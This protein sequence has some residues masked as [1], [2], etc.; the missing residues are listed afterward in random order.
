MQDSIFS[1]F[2]IRTQINKLLSLLVGTLVFSFSAD[3]FAQAGILEELV[4]TAQK[5]EE[6]IQDV[7]I[8]ITAFSGEQLKA[9]GFINNT[10]VAA[11]TP[12]VYI[13][14]NN[15]GHTQQFSIRGATQNDFADVA[16]APNAVY[17][18]EAYQATGQSQLFASFD[19]ERV[20]ILKGPQGTLFGRNATGGL[21]HYI[22]NKPTQEKEAYIDVGYGSYDSVRAEGAVSGALSDTISARVAGMYSGH[23]DVLDNVFT[24]ASL[25][26]TPGALV[27]AGGR[28]PTLTSNPD[29]HDDLWT[30][31]QWAL[32]GQLL[33]QPNDDIE[34]LFKAQYA[35]SKPASGPYQHAATVA[36]VDDTDGDGVEDQ[37]V[38]TAF[39][40]D[41][42]TN[43]ETISVNTGLCVNSIFDGD[44]DGVRP[45]DRGDFFGFSEA[46]GQEGLDVNTDH[47]TSDNDQTKL[48]G[49]GGTLRWNLD[50]AELISV[51]SYSHQTKRQ[52]LDVDSGPA[53]QFIVMNQSEF[54][55][56][57]QELRLE[58]ETDRF[59]WITGAYYLNI[60][61]K[62]AQG[63]ADTLGG[64]N[65]FGGLFFGP[66]FNDTNG[67]GTGLPLNI[68][69]GEVGPTAGGDTFLEGT[70]NA[71]LET[72][73]YSIFGQID[74][75]LTDQLTFN[76]G[77]RGIIEEK[78]YSY[79]SR[80]YNNVRDSRTDGALFGGGTALPIIF[81]PTAPLE[82]LAPFQDKTSDF[83]WS[84]KVQ[85]NYAFSDDLLLYGGVNRGVKAG[86]FNAPL[87]TNL[88]Q[89]DYGYDEEILLSYEI[90]F[91][92]TILDGKARLNMSAYY[93][94]YTDY[95]GFQFV[96]TSG[97]VFNVDA[98]YKGF[99]AELITSPTDNIDMIFSFGY[100][101]AKVKDVLVAPNRPRDVEP[102][103]TPEVQ[104]SGLGR[105]TWPNVLMGGSVTLQIDGNYAS[106]TFSN[107][108][109]FGTHKQDGYWIG[110]ARVRWISQDERWEVGGF[111]NNFSDTR[112]QLIGFELSAISGS[113]EQSFGKPRW[114]GVS[115]RY[116]Y[117]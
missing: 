9:F 72:N 79:T 101:D 93:Y 106:K 115:L 117:F 40:R 11:Y 56:F 62:Y 55:W 4:V 39:N 110:N 71:E 61:G 8:A 5:R 12:G 65:I 42:R 28:A 36:F 102:A 59:R 46:D 27:G 92:S 33:F 52:S 74:Y 2:F 68:I 75:D 116:N 104:F 99:E 22:T 111:V 97:A 51:S 105:Y 13:S 17:V 76:L 14:G 87:L 44:F 67:D 81:N 88:A 113:D 6:S 73:S 25:P 94:D 1:N 41:L 103:F 31:D 54:D 32:R 7:G 30:E 84:G 114:A 34:F 108:N 57:S 3:T 26:P 37:T 86:S 43:C 112:N 89:E 18:D 23:D 16:E 10:E 70:L 45:N 60:D 20:E 82:F 38:D 77:F 50:W 47:T 96:G 98:V 24:D 21:V 83:L 91:K 58:G 66:V 107:I 80:L 19:M 53:P 64:I 109:N 49:F 15:G 85:L 29:N 35:Q 78:D 100:I 63:L 69:T 95:Q 90:G 48:Y